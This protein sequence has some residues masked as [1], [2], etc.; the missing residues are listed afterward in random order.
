[1]QT[2]YTKME[3]TVS[4]IPANHEHVNVVIGSMLTL[5]PLY[6]RVAGVD[7]DS[8]KKEWI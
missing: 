3:T 4:I 1:M 8:W 2:H 6:N 5:A 7:A